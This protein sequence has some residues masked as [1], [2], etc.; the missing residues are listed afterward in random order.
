M[1]HFRDI[2]NAANNRPVW[3]VLSRHWLSLVGVGF[4]STAVI[5]WLFVLPLSV[6][7]HADNPYLGIVVFLIVPVLFFA[8]LALIPIGIYLGK[9]QIRMGLTEAPFDRRAVLSRIAWFFGITTL[10]N[11]LIGTQFTYRAVKHMETP[12]FC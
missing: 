12:Q 9:R 11:L 2:I 8:G 3:I 5:T 10:A 6:R 7:G 4:V 1:A